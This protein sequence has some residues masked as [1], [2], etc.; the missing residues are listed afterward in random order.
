[1]ILQVF[2]IF[3]AGVF[4]A[5]KSYSFLESISFFLSQ[6]FSQYCITW[7]VSA[8]IQKVNHLDGSVVVQEP[9]LA[10][11]HDLNVVFGGQT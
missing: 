9:E 11:T 2:S 6:F 10:I 3:N 7:F 8:A 1:M 4:I 5:L